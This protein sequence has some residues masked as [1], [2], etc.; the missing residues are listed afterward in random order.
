MKS[1]FIGWI[2]QKLRE[3]FVRILICIGNLIG[4]MH[5][6]M[7][8]IGI[9][10][11]M[12]YNDEPWF[13]AGR[14]SILDRMDEMNNRW[15][16]PKLIF[17]HLHFAIEFFMQKKYFAHMQG[18]LP[19]RCEQYFFVRRR[20]GHTKMTQ[21]FC[22]TL[23]SLYCV[24]RRTLDFWKDLEVFRRALSIIELWWSMPTVAWNEPLT[25]FFQYI[26]TW[27]NRIK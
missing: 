4:D 2:M 6:P 7:R 11:K 20:T 1:E 10:S 16:K 3:Q 5:Y 15:N 19:I 8:S 18:Y 21:H 23:N 12:V 27:T 24:K 17:N 13:K 26:Y 25:I 22:P 9:C 14:D